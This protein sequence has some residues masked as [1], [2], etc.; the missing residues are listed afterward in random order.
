MDKC[1]SYDRKKFINDFQ[2]ILNDSILS[3]EELAMK[4]YR[5]IDYTLEIECNVI[6]NITFEEYYSGI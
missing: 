3:N 5:F 1:F 2:K 4:C 6:N